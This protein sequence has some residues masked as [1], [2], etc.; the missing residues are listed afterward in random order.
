MKFSSSAVILA[1]LVVALAMSNTVSAAPPKASATEASPTHT[2]GDKPKA[3][4][5][6]GAG[7]GPTVPIAPPPSLSGG[8]PSAPSGSGPGASPSP[9]VR[10][11]ANGKIGSSFLVTVAG[12]GAAMA[13]G[14]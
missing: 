14:L 8:G 9:S 11:A 12:I 3:T 4:A 10:S 7:A 13:V 5:T 2:G 6:G 1:S